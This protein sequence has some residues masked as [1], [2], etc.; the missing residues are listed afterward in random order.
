MTK[1]QAECNVLTKKVEELTC[2]NKD[3][4]KQAAQTKEELTRAKKEIKANATREEWLTAEL[5]RMNAQLKTNAET[6]QKKLTDKEEALKKSEDRN[7]LLAASLEK[8][9]AYHA[10]IVQMQAE[11]KAICDGSLQQNED[12][13]YLH[14][15]CESVRPPPGFVFSPSGAATSVLCATAKDFIPNSKLGAPASTTS[16]PKSDDILGGDVV[17]L[18]KNKFLDYSLLGSDQVKSA[19]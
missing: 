8:Q 10:K 4:E 18:N 3:L 2:T 17:G 19:P 6:A 15:R 11:A 1:L 16:E 9:S 14:P 5:D 7:R 12:R 13:R